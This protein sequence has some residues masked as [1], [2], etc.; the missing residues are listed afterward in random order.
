MVR[1]KTYNFTLAT[2]NL[3]TLRD[4]IN[5]LN[6]G[7]TA[8]ILTTSGGNYL[9][10]S[11][12]STGAATLHLSTTLPAVPLSGSHPVTRGPTLNSS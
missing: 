7:V 2:N 11:A 8:S 5:S 10:I 6:A 9:S 1:S 3:V 12:N 4:T